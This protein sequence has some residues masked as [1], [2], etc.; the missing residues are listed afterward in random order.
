M[1][2]QCMLAM[3]EQSARLCEERWQL[4]L[5]RLGRTPNTLSPSL[6]T[7]VARAQRRLSPQGL[8]LLWALIPT[9]LQ[10]FPGYNSSL[11]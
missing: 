10:V 5:Y 6:S 11:V 8:G 3:R 4:S 9:E 1:L 7:S 2:A